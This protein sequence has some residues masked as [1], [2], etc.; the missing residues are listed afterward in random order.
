VLTPDQ[1]LPHHPGMHRRRFLLTSMAGAFAAPLAAGAQAARRSPRVGIVLA[2]APLP[3]MAGP[4]PAQ[5]VM[6]GFIH[7][8]RALGYVDGQN[9]SIERRSSEGVPERQEDLILGLAQIPVDVIV[10]PTNRMALLAKKITSTVPVVALMDAPVESGIVQSLARPGGNV[11]GLTLAGD[12]PGGKRLEIVRQVLPKGSRIA[13]LGRKEEWS[14]QEGQALRGAARSLGL[15]LFL[16]DVQM[17]LL[18]PALERLDRERVDGLFVSANPVFFVHVK[19]I[20]D[21]AARLRVP[22]FH[23]YAHAVEAGGFASYGHDAYDLFRRAAGF[24]DR[25]LKGANPREMPV[26]QVERYALV[27]NLKTARALGLTIPQ[28][29]LQ[30]ADRVI[31]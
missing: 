13:F 17:P 4:E 30:R 15:T 28:S 26:E 11:T 20:A 5:I 2:S 29:V 1:H 27:L 22:D 18:G 9:I 23:L 3:T 10:V 6:R 21:F 8:L 12:V 31:E 16:A 24:V 19:Q 25:I 7:G 14:S